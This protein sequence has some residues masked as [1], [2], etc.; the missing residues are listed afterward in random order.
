MCVE[1]AVWDRVLLYVVQAGLIL[2][3]ILLSASGVMGLQVCA[4]MLCFD[5]QVFLRTEENF[6][7]IRAFSLP[8]P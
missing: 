8:L 6:L 1:G 4:T 7:V 3:V 5:R 2:K